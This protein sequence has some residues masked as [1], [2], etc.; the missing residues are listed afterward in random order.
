LQVV[1]PLDG[2]ETTGSLTTWAAEAS[3]PLLLRAVAAIEAGTAVGLV[4]DETLA[5]SC[6][7]VSKDQGR[8][9]WS[10]SAV[11]L[12]ARIRAYDPWPGAFTAWGGQRLSLKQSSVAASA[13]DGEVGKVI[14][15]DKSKGILVQ[16]G[17]GLVAVRELQLPGRKSMDFRSFLNGNPSL[18]GSRLGEPS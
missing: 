15:V 9:D 4:Q 18:V 2:T 14:A 17:D 5:T 10:R 12:D 8:L 7:L 3:A 13:G 11:D 1:R 6:S 16:T